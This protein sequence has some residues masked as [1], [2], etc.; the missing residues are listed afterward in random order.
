MVSTSNVAARRRPVAADRWTSQAAVPADQRAIAFAVWARRRSV[1]RSERLRPELQHL[2]PPGPCNCPVSGTPAR[3]FTSATPGGLRRRPLAL[4]GRLPHVVDAR[5]GRIGRPSRHAGNGVPGRPGGQDRLANVSAARWGPVAPQRDTPR[6]P[7]GS[8]PVVRH[9]VR[10]AGVGDDQ[11]SPSR[12]PAAA[13]AT[14]KSADAPGTSP[15]ALGQASRQE[16]VGGVEQPP[17]RQVV[18][19]STPATSPVGGGLGLNGDFQALA[20]TT[21]GSRGDRGE[22]VGG[23]TRPPVVTTACLRPRESYPT[24]PRPA[25]LAP[26]DPRETIPVAP[27]HVPAD[28]PASQVHRVRRC[29]SMRPPGNVGRPA[30]ARWDANRRN[31]GATLPPTPPRRCVCRRPPAFAVRP[32]LVVVGVGWGLCGGGGGGGGGGGLGG[33]GPGP[34]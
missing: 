29:P 1:V 9:S 32:C 19:P 11:P 6:S 28:R 31:T 14:T 13:V 21:P 30:A 15:A 33:D 27:S 34:W 2:A 24:P 3:R 26:W 23:F 16:P 17:R 20:P 4:L 8:L 10:T 12:S 22:T 5:S 18:R 25:G 7:R